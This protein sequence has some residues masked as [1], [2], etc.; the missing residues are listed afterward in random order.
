MRKDNNEEEIMSKKYNANEKERTM[1]K[2]KMNLVR[3][4]VQCPGYFGKQVVRRNCEKEKECLRKI[5]RNE[6]EDEERLLS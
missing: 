1:R 3:V 4:P 2:N 5:M 6:K